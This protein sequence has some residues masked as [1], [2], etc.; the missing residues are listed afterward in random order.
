MHMPRLFIDN[1]TVI[2]CSILDPER[3]LIGA[4]WAVNIEL[5][6]EL[7]HQSMV[8][9][10]AKVKKTIKRIIDNEVD[11]KL[12]IPSKFSGTQIIS[13][14][15]HALHIQF[16]D[17]NNEFINHLSPAQAVC[18]IDS[19]RISRTAVIDYLN[20]IIM[21]ELPNN[22]QQLVI[23]LHEEAVTGNYYRYS[24]GLEKHDG[25]CQRIAHGHRSQVQIWQNGKRDNALEKSIATRWHDIY[26]GSDQHVVERKDRRIQFAYKTD[27]GSFD[28]SLP[29]HRVHLM[30]CDSTVECIADHLLSLLENE[31]DNKNSF[32]VK[33]FE[34]IGKGAIS[35]TKP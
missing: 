15:E 4:S 18:L 29:E 30:D 21:K 5:F 3:G 8:F 20:D 14:D 6:G 32:K 2:D 19:E 24:H 17:S 11:H 26:L 33:A 23:E 10:F 28:I 9:D 16:T 31:T 27:Q 7:D 22:V 34:G 13:N 35:Q 25:N 12:V 1:L